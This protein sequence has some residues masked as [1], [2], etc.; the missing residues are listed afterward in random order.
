MAI[1]PEGYDFA[2]PDPEEFRCMRCNPHGMNRTG[3]MPI[4]LYGNTSTCVESVPCPA[5]CNH[6]LIEP[7]YGKV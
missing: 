7:V 4:R 3:W 6:G 2:R 5:G 1:R